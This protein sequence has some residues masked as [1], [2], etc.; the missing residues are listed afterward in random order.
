M[1]QNEIPANNTIGIVLIIDELLFVQH[2][3]LDHVL[4]LWCDK[5]ILM[6]HYLIFAMV[7]KHAFLPIT[8]LAFDDDDFRWLRTTE[9]DYHHE[10]SFNDLFKAKSP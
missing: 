1:A 10:T 9:K 7:F 8:A 6:I 2:A 4:R 5:S 3:K